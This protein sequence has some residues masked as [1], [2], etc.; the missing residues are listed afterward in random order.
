MSR[1][2]IFDK[3]K[4][5]LL[6][7]TRDILECNS[8]DEDN[9]SVKINRV[10][11]KANIMPLVCRVRDRFEQVEAIHKICKE[12]DNIAEADALAGCFK[13]AALF[14]KPNPPVTQEEKTPGYDMW[15]Q[16]SSYNQ[17]PDSRFVGAMLMIYGGSF[18][19]VKK[20]YQYD[21]ATD[22]GSIPPFY[23]SIQMPR[24]CVCGLEV[25]YGDKA[26][27]QM[28]ADWCPLSVYEREG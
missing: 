3:Y 8:F 26:F 9:V 19:E 16:A 1:S 27:K 4:H 21:F 14:F 5:L 11:K 7:K 18:Y 13:H 6:P 23:P 10:V 22:E 28:H 12:L 20:W 15:S 25:I 17:F 24:K 2:I